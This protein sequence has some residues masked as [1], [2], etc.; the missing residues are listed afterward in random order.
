VLEFLLPLGRRCRLRG[1]H[2][3]LR[4]PLCK[5]GMRTPR[6]WAKSTAGAGK[7]GFRGTTPEYLDIFKETVYH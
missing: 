2:P 1:K 3:V 7:G 6:R 5:R 4:T